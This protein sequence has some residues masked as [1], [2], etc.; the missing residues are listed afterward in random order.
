MIIA[1][2]LAAIVDVSVAD[3]QTIEAAAAALRRMHGDLAA[4]LE[5][6]RILRLE[7]QANA[8]KLAALEQLRPLV[9][10]F[11]RSLGERVKVENE[12][13]QTVAGQ[14]ELPDLAKCR[15]WA[16]RLGIP[17]ETSRLFAA[18]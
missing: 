9:D 15:S 11:A 12:L 6:N 4:A 14:I 2:E 13:W 16:Q 1:D 7:M 3:A 10:A 18:K 5:M 8:S 17:D